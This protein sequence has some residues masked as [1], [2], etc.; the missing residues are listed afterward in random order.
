MNLGIDID[1][2]EFLGLQRFF[3]LVTLD[4]YLAIL[5]KDEVAYDAYTTG[6]KILKEL[7][8]NTPIE[9]NDLKDDDFFGD[10]FM[11]IAIFISKDEAS[12]LAKLV[13]VITIIDLE[14]IIK[15]KEMAKEANNAFWGMKEVLNKLGSNLDRPAWNRN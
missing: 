14:N 8:A 5:K 9:I 3:K 7:I 15:N 13:R 1:Y 4:D 6:K 12:A 10:G 11:S 2:K